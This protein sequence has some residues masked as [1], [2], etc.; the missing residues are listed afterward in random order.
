MVYDRKCGVIVM[1]SDLVEEGQV[2]MVVTPATVVIPCLPILE[3]CYQ[4]WPSTGSQKFGEFTVELLQEER[5]QGFMLRAVIQ[6]ELDSTCDM[7]I[8][9]MVM[10]CTFPTVWQLP[11][12]EPV[13]HHQLGFRHSLLQPEYCD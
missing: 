13:P 2:R 11:A 5:L 12:C 9:G 3:V 6:G 4:H 10:D 8:L 7:R 1:L